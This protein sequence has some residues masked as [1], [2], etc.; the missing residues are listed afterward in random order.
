MLAVVLGMFV[1]GPLLG[2]GHRLAGWLGLGRLFAFA[3]NWLRWPFACALLMGWATLVYSIAPNRRTRWRH[4]LPGAVLATVLWLA[5]SLGFAG[6]LR[7]A[8]AGNKILGLLGGG[9]ILL[10][11]LYL[12]ALALLVGGELNGVLVDRARGGQLAPG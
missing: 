6:Y 5:V 9:L 12:L 7:L 11:W 3:W 1:I 4:E 10:V 2:L 8:A